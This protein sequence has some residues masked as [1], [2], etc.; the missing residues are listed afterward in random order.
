MSR[1]GERGASDGVLIDTSAIDGRERYQLLTSL[2]VPRPIGWLSTRGHGVANLAPF[3]YFAAL[4]ATPMLV[5]VSIGSRRGEDKDSIRNIR[6][7]GGFCVNV[8]TEHFLE[9]MNASSGDHPSDVDEFRIA[10]LPA[11]EAETVDA[12][13]VASCPAVLE[14]R[15]FREVELGEA[16]AVL[17]IGEVLAIRLAGELVPPGGGYHVDPAVLRPVARL[18]G[19]WYAKLGELVRLPRPGLT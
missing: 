1:A 8:V 9:P 5:G 15:L 2:V 14:C 12:P 7:T 18:G 10:G 17:I 11:A 16:P 4:S 19:E 13:Y 3:S 6:E